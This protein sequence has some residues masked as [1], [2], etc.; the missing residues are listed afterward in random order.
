MIVPMI[1]PLFQLAKSSDDVEYK[2][3]VS[4]CYVILRFCAVQDYEGGNLI[5]CLGLRSNISN[6]GTFYCVM[7]V[8]VSF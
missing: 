6:Y 1:G 7:Y 2:E 5:Y 3:K 4:S 8:V